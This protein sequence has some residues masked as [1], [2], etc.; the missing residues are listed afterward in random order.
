V[1]NSAAHPSASGSLHSFS[2][3]FTKLDTVEEFEVKT[4]DKF[5]EQ[6][7]KYINSL[8]DAEGGAL[9]PLIREVHIRCHADA[10]SSGAVLVDLPGIADA[11]AAR[12]NVAAGY[13]KEAHR[14]WIVAPIT[15]AVD[16]G[17]AQSE[18]DAL[19]A[20]RDSD[21]ETLFKELLG[22]MFK[23]QLLSTYP[24]SHLLTGAGD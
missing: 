19:I 22:D 7:D 9:W 16:D 20:R 4:S 10:L 8:D 23:T 15:R 13:M 17:A 3:I 12:N 11:N 5:T 24:C 18:L 14:I 21:P 6:V 1:R 2:G